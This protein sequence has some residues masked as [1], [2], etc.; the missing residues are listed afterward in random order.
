MEQTLD[1]AELW[2]KFN[3]NEFYKYKELCPVC[4]QPLVAFKDAKTGLPK[5]QGA[6][7]NCGYKQE[8]N[9]GEHK[10]VKQ[11]QR[12][13]SMSYLAERSIIA[14]LSVFNHKFS[15]YAANTAERQQVLADAKAIGGGLINGELIHA[16][17]TGRP[18]TG[19]THLAIAIAYEV[20]EKSNYRKQITVIEWLELLKRKLQPDMA[21]K[22][23][24]QIKLAC[25]ADFIILDGLGNENT[26]PTKAS[27]ECTLL[28]TT[29]L[30]ALANKPL[31]VTTRLAGKDIRAAY[32]S[33]LLDQI[34]AHSSGHYAIFNN[35]ADWRRS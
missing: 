35:I 33:L 17:F 2:Q 3:N 30:A 7:P 12:E 27:N 34:L 31:L 24:H 10:Q 5:S 8:N 32:G 22:I 28:L 13:Q 9:S 1:T 15:N 20:L 19:K 14:S 18:G 25:E 4:G 21:D 16:I 26:S 6:C 23:N 29:L 11:S